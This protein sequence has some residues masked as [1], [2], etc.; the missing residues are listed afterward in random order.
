M[1][2]NFHGWNLVSPFFIH[3]YWEMQAITSCNKVKIKSLLVVLKSTFL[4]KLYL[5]FAYNVNLTT[6]K[7]EERK[8]WSIIYFSWKAFITYLLHYLTLSSNYVCTLTMS[9]EFRPATNYRWGPDKR[10]L[11]L[12]Q[13]YNTYA[14]SF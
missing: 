12:Q 14:L 6:E 11:W 2:K 8:S 3:D 13:P 4:L 1:P 9:K 7:H 5:V 10:L